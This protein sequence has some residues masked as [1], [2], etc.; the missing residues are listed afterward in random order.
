MAHYAYRKD[1]I[2]NAKTNLSFAGSVQILASSM[3]SCYLRDDSVLMILM[4]II[5]CDSKWLLKLVPGLISDLPLRIRSQFSFDITES[6]DK[7]QKKN[8]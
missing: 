5:S 8:K 1:Q 3:A 2:L 4:A 7:K 6:T